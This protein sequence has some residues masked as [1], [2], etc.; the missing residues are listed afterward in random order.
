M[1][2]VDQVKADLASPQMATGIFGEDTLALS[3]ALDPKDVYEQARRYYM[4]SLSAERPSGSKTPQPGRPEN[5]GKTQQTFAH[6]ALNEASLTTNSHELGEDTHR[7]SQEPTSGRASGRRL[8]SHRSRGKTPTATSSYSSRVQPACTTTAF[9]GI[10]TMDDFAN[11]L[12]AKHQAVVEQT[13]K[14]ADENS[15]RVMHNDCYTPR[16]VTEKEVELVCP[17]TEEVKID[18]FNG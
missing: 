18:Q 12:L 3:G 17:P 1:D 2:A 10:S 8:R 7:T 14:P 13:S 5:L 16:I 11:M 4:T 15:P 9:K 6:D